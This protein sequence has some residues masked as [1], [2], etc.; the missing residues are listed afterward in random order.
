MQNF[1]RI[2][3]PGD[4]RIAA[5]R[6]IRERDL[7]GRKGRFVAERKVVL[8]ALAGHPRFVAESVLVLENRLDGLADELEMLSAQTPV[9]VVTR[10]VLDQIAGFPMHRGILAIGLRQ[11]FERSSDLLPPKTQKCLVVVCCGISNHDNIG[12]IFRN[13]AAFGADAVLLDR[14][15]CDPLYRKALR[16]SVGAVLKVPFAACGPIDEIIALLSENAIEALSLSPSGTNRIDEI[17]PPHRTAIILGTEGDGLPPDVLRSTNPV[18]V[19]MTP[20][21][22]SLNV[23]AASAIALHHLSGCKA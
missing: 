11:E 18:R 7:V 4:E 19:A 5:Y 16:V 12:S 6:N 10:E 15:C 22:D 21:F 2:D 17:R 14:T 9:F 23:A 1:I 3:D 13:A 20:G 8:R